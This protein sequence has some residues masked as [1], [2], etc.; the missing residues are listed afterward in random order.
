MASF[1]NLDSPIKVLK[2]VFKYDNF[3]QGQE[4]AI[5]KILDGNSTLCIFPTGAGKSLCYQ[6][7]AILLKGKIT[8]VISP[9]LS[10]VRDQI[11]ELTQRGIKTQTL[12]STQSPEQQQ[13]IKKSLEE[14]P[15]QVLFISPE[16]LLKKEHF[17]T[18]K[19][20]P[21]GL[22]VIDE[23]HCVSEWGNSFRP[24]Y[25]LVAKEIRKLKP[26]AVLALTATANKATAREIRKAFKIK[27][28]DQVQTPL[29]RPNLAFRIVPS[30]QKV[31]LPLLLKILQNS[32][33]SP[34]IV[35]VMRQV[36]TER[37][38]AFLS[39][40]KLNSRSYHAGMP[41]EA[42]KKV[43]DAFM[44]DSIDI[45]V[46]TIA[47]GMGVNKEN[48]R[49]VIH[50]HIPKSPEGWMQES[51]RAGRDGKIANCILLASKDDFIPL[52]N[53]NNS[54]EISYTAVEGVLN[55]IFS[56]GRQISISKYNLKINY[57]IH[58]AQLDII[59]SKLI[60]AGII[61]YIST[62]W[63]FYQVSK[64][65]YSFD[66]L[67]PA[68]KK[69]VQSVLQHNGRIDVLDAKNLFS[70]SSKS[71]IQFLEELESV[72][73]ISIKRSSI[74]HHYILKKSTFDLNSLTQEYA[75]AFNEQ[76]LTSNNRLNAIH[77]IATGKKCIQFHFAQY[78]GEKITEN[79]GVCSSCISSKK[80][81]KIQT[82]LPSTPL[83]EIS[84]E[85]LQTLK[86]VYQKNSKKLNS[87]IR[88]AKFAC[89][90]QSPII[91]HYR[92]YQD[93]EY[94]FL[95]DFPI[96]DVITSCKALISG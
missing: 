67:P 47:F 62:S 76:I 25:L 5:S 13:E 83:P 96:S 82:Q 74:L 66:N 88:L 60:S 42:R 26:H 89:G 43:Q 94:G 10:L 80:A 90:I 20:L 64:L 54:V 44:D 84:L 93:D 36:D 63:R 56:Q 69:L 32:Q 92:L 35:Y 2:A 59:I 91:F 73:D 79:C 17:N 23:A 48:I 29:F 28:Q 75:D 68:K 7:P 37:V 86:T 39:K 4:E 30:E 81:Q 70:I 52:E 31:K 22:T 53:Y 61:E 77:T 49:T 78:F 8:L 14:Q 9:L 27:T 34:A 41:A 46:A 40:N 87:P 55:T 16:S 71:L 45:V 72:G 57:D 12:D 58:D 65:K 11:K 38:N 95:S 6:I 3:Q 24:S 15:H 19:N 85:Q 51:G 50:Y 18:L 21:I 33:N 1:E